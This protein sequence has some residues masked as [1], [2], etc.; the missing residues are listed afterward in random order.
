MDVMD[1]CRR[2]NVSGYV[3]HLTITVADCSVSTSRES[4]MEY[5]S[6]VLVMMVNF[7]FFAGVTANVIQHQLRHSSTLPETM[8]S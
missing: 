3:M 1:L 8:T 7:A 4:R 2:S 6:P 5:L